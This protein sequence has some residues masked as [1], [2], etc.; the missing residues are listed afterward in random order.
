MARQLPCGAKRAES[1]WRKIKRRQGELL[2][3]AVAI[4]ADGQAGIVAAEAEAVADGGLQT[5]ITLGLEYCPSATS[6]I[7]QFTADTRV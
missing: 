1:P 4:L 2:C 6:C 3:F 5:H 7:P